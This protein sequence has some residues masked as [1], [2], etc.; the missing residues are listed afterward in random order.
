MKKI[1][2]VLALLVAS[3]AAFADMGLF[4]DNTKQFARTGVIQASFPNTPLVACPKL[5][6]CESFLLTNTNVSIFYSDLK[7]WLLELK[8]RAFAIEGV[9]V[10]GTK[11]GPGYKLTVH[12]ITAYGGNTYLMVGIKS[13][14]NTTK[15]KNAQIAQAL[16]GVINEAY[17][18][19]SFNK[20]FC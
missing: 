18:R 20:E 14:K 2:L 15:A 12:E 5:K 4:F 13:A 8:K 9:Q 3:S 10:I 6:S 11:S 19:G 7:K 1:L 16:V 17:V